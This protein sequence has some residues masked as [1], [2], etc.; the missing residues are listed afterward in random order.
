MNK[1][2]I[3]TILVIITLF[4]NS[5]YSQNVSNNQGI[6]TISYGEDSSLILRSD[7]PILMMLDSLADL[8]YF[9]YTDSK[10][11]MGLCNKYNFSQSDIPQYSDSVYAARLEVL[12]AKSPFNLVYYK[13]VKAF[14]DLYTIRKRDLASRILGLSNLYFPYFETMLD[15]FNLPLE[16]KY[17]AV[18]E[19]SLNTT[20]NSSAGAKGMWQFMYPTGKQYNLEVTSYIDERCDPYKSTVAACRYFTNLYKIYG[21][22]Y[23][24]LA[25][26][27]YGTGN[28]NKAIRKAG[29]AL[30]FWKISRFLP[31]ETRSYIPAFIAVNYF[32]NYHQ[33]HNL[34]PTVPK[35]LYSNIDTVNLKRSVNFKQISEVLGVSIEELSY[36]NPSYK[37]GVIPFDDKKIYSLVLPKDHIGNFINNEELIYNYK[38]EELID[39]EEEPKVLARYHKVTKGQTLSLLA[40]KYKC[41]LADIKKWNNL[42]SSHLKIGSNLIVYYNVANEPK[43]EEVKKSKEEIAEKKKEIK[44]DTVLAQNVKKIKIEKTELLSDFCK[45]YNLN[46]EEIKNLNEIKKDT[47]FAGE[48]I[49][50]GYKENL[51]NINTVQKNTNKDEKYTYY[52]IQKGDTL[53]SIASKAN[54][55]VEKIVKINNLKS[56]NAVLKPGQKIKVKNNNNS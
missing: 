55:T 35:N 43:R 14:I 51:K 26:Y 56:K 53:W 6:D 17:L 2:K 34:Y 46:V 37:K 50:L 3:S 20:A 21:D 16:L 7:F 1:L 24:V 23:L 30:D 33:E 39:I 19:S 11:S 45:N 15:K 29:G 52:T 18:V 12:N 25:A 10:I 49:I 27:N 47:V 28:V 22:W 40:K 13:D 41:S 48:H 4:F 44:A 31:A 32:M 38:K 5:V 8:K 9:E 42:R 36:L 54:V